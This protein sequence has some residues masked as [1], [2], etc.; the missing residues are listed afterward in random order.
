VVEEEVT[1]VAAEEART[2]AEVAVAG[3]RIA[4]LSPE[5]FDLA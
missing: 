2:A 4:K 3:I 1:L 5:H